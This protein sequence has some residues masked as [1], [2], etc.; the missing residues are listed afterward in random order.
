MIYLVRHGETIWNLEGRR[1]GHLD[2]PLTDRGYAQAKAVAQQ[3]SC[4]L[5]NRKGVRIISSPLGRA[6]TT[7]LVIAQHLSLTQ[8]KIVSEPLLSEHHMGC[9][10]GFTNQQVDDRYPGD[11][12]RRNENKWEYTI[13]G[14]ESYARVYER[15]V[16]WISTIS[17]DWTVIAVTHEMISRTI[18]GAYARLD[19]SH[20]LALHHPHDVVFCLHQ[21]K[22]EEI[23]CD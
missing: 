5:E 6:M 11:R 13:P 2:S 9:W 18:R 8:N 15:A 1:Q 19:R 23:V 14:G 16:A 17:E 7:A 3:L 12:K 21:G 20:M 4:E 10:Q 22:I